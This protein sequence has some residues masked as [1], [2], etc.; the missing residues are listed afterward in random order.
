MAIAGIPSGYRKFGEM[1]MGR[2]LIYIIG[3]VMALAA[4]GVGSFY[5]G[6]VYAAQQA[7]ST[8]AAFLNGRGGAGVT[9][10]GGEGNARGAGGGGGGGGGPAPARPPRGA[11]RGRAS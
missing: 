9:G 5:G 7:S 8:R 1:N 4:V 3:I 10:G 2:K 11:G 6:T